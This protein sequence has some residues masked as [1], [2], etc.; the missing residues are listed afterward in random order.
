M[1]EPFWHEI[2]ESLRLMPR[3]ESSPEL[4]KLA[5]QALRDGYAS[6]R[7]KR[8][9][10]SVLSQDETG[11][12]REFYS[13]TDEETAEALDRLNANLKRLRVEGDAWDGSEDDSLT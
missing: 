6:E 7:E 11:E 13:M 9:A 12:S 10:A 5:S 1:S 2:E 4:S 8:L 3:K